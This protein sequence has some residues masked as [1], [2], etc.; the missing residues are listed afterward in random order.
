MTDVPRTYHQTISANL[1]VA[2]YADGDLTVHVHDEGGIVFEP[3]QLRELR[4]ALERLSAGE[5]L[6]TSLGEN[7]HGEEGYLEWDGWTVTLYGFPSPDGI[8]LTKEEAIALEKLLRE[9]GH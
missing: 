2:A 6:V 9:L 3:T 7:C 1:T 4:T 8:E 5:S